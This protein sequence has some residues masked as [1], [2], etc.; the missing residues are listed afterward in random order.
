V[1][2]YLKEQKES[3]VKYGIKLAEVLLQAELKQEPKRILALL[4]PILFELE[5]PDQVII[6][7]AHSRYHQALNQRLEIMKQNSNV[8]YAILDDNSL[9][10]DKVTVESDEALLT[11]DI[12]E[13]LDNYFKALIEKETA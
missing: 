10:L 3:I 7:K 1:K 6:I 4:E 5:K 8:R 2:A 9:D 13:E 12:H 11:L